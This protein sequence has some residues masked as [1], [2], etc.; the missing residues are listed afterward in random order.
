[1]TT[2]KVALITGAGTGIGKASA[3]ALAKAGYNV[4]LAGRRLEPLQN[5]ARE[6]E[7][8]GVRAVAVATDVGDHAQ[9]KA[10]FAKTKQA[11]GRLDVLFNNAG[12]GT[13]AMPLEDLSYEQWK[14]VVDV[15]LT[16]PF[17]CTQEA[18]RIMKD[19]TPRGGRIINNGSI[20]AYAPRP[21]SAPYTSTKHAIT[22][23]TKASSLDGRAYDIA[24]G[25]IDIGN[26]AT[27]MTER[28]KAGVLQPDGSTRAEPRMDVEHVANAVVHMASLPLDANVLFMTVMA[29]KMP[30]VGRG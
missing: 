24:V 5:A 28:M 15:N 25:Q 7:A 23:L 14:A 3:I 17:L 29:T 22:G 11:F 9:V 1:M 26:A 18:F 6:A 8:H 16:G 27:E 20:S 21:F 19:Q 13:P 2:T 30:F 4:V 10:L 12:M